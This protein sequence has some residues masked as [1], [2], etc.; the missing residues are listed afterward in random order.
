MSCVER[1]WTVMVMVGVTMRYAMLDRLQCAAV[2]LEL[3]VVT[4]IEVVGTL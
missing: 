3:T 4:G 1:T 2:S